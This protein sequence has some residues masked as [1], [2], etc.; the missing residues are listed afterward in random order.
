MFLGQVRRRSRMAILRDGMKFISRLL[1]LC[2]ACAL[3]V[4]AH[5]T[6]F[7]VNSQSDVVDVNPGDGTCETAPSDAVCTL[8]AGVQEAGP[9]ACP[10]TIIVAAGL[11]VLTATPSC[12][13]FLT[14]NPTLIAENMSALCGRG[15]VTIKGAGSGFHVH[16]S[17][18]R[19]RR[20]L[21]RGLSFRLRN[22][23]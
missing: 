12:S 6:T 3:A 23:S 16:Q 8:R 10:H 13:Y 5:A 4:P 17:Q 22:G 2:A 14:G 19:R 11:Y 1:V 20:H 21:L 9:T 18:C 15:H 7:T